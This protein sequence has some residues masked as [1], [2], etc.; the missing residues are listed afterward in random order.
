MSKP[1]DESVKLLLHPLKFKAFLLTRLPA[2]L[3]SGVKIVSANENHCEVSIPYKWFTRNPF[4]STY[5]ACLSMAA[6]MSTGALAM[7]H[8]QNED[9]KVSMLVVKV[10]GEF[11][12]KATG[13]AFFRCEGGDEIKRVIKNCIATNEPGTIR[14]KSNGRNKAGEIIAEFYITWSF[15]ARTNKNV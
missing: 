5:F 14:A 6:E 9:Q 4:R 15:K 3:F 10:E 13:R 7:M 2:A 8:A 11:F 1:T 12:K